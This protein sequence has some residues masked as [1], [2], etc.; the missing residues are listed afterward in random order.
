MDIRDP[1]PPGLEPAVIAIADRVARALA[2]VPEVVAVALGGSRGA[3]G[4]GHD[5]GSDV[6]I[7]VYTRGDIPLAVRHRVMI[8]AGAVPPLPVDHDFWGPADEWLDPGTGIVVDVTYF[9]ATWMDD[10]LDRVLVRHEPSLGYS[11]CFWHTI[12]GGFALHDPDGWLAGLQARAAVPYPEG[13]RVAIVTRNRAALR[14]F[15][16]AWEIQVAKAERR[17]DPVSANHRVAGMLASCFDIV[18]AVNRVTHPGEKRLLAAVAGQC[19]IRPPDF[20]AGVRAVLAAAAAAAV[21]DGTLGAATA[22]LLD[23]IDRMLADD[24]AL[25]H[26]L[27]TSYG[28]GRAPLG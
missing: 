7:E 28:P 10:Q 1:L 19:P 20:E 25:A 2:A 24:P 9:D 16:S 22:R 11:T 6:D 26:C 27:D 15:P 18:F 12:Q 3:G 4:I 13:L 17:A 23:G 21:A 14:D 5:A 8:E